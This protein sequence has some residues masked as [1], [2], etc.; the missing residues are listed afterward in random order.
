M[1][2]TEPTRSATFLVLFQ[3]DRSYQFA[4]YPDFQKQLETLKIFNERVS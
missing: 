4:L 3:T 1:F 2:T